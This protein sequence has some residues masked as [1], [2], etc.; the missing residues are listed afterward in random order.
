MAIRELINRQSG[1]KPGMAEMGQKLRM[2]GTSRKDK[3]LA[4]LAL[5]ESI[6][7]EVGPLH[8]ALVAKNEST[9]FYVDHCDTA[10]LKNRWSTDKTVDLSKL[11][12]DAVWGL[13]T[14]REAIDNSELAMQRNLQ[15]CRLDFLLASHVVEHVP[16]MITWF[17][18][19]H[20]V[21]KPDGSVRLA[22]PDKRYSF[23][24]LRRTST[25]EDVA[26]GFVR[27]RRVPSGNRVLDFTLNMVNVDCGKAWSNQINPNELVHGYTVAQSLALAEDA[28]N[29][30]TYHDVH[31]WVFTP[32]TFADLCCE[33]SAAGLLQFECDL[34]VPTVR[35]EFEFFVWMRP[36]EDAGRNVESWK[37]A[38]SSL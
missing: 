22:V 17:R 15:G 16:D 8:N 20:S 9:I 31:C 4:M 2:A 23:D 29:N 38:A 24:I 37:L 27:R 35:N 19:I 10:T 14:L 33:L 25:I 28:E 12:V 6:G 18:E 7:A 1:T 26:D 32:S 5:G 36:C 34:I 30:G 13:H 11:H 21:L 3:L